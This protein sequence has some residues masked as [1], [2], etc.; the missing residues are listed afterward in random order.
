[1]R[2]KTLLRALCMA[3]FLLA[4]ATL[5]EGCKKDDAPTGGGGGGGTG[6]IT[7][8]LDGGGFYKSTITR[9]ITLSNCIGGYDA[10]DNSAGVYGS[11][12]SGSDSVIAVVVWRGN[13]A[14]NFSWSDSVGFGL[15]LKSGSTYRAYASLN[16]PGENN[17]TAFPA[18]GGNITGMFSGRVIGGV[19]GGSTLD[20][21]TVSNGT[22]SC[23]R[24]E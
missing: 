8:T 19:S 6:T 1:M 20:T 16:V 17:I 5:H 23:R 7:F 9:T 12:L 10:T 4:I 11:G 14:G 21:V 18:V 15:T 24:V 3:V 2:N 13:Q 22:F